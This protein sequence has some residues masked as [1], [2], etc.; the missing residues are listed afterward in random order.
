MLVSS[1]H[2][3]RLSSPSQLASNLEASRDPRKL[4]SYDVVIVAASYKRDHARRS[5]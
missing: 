5:A 4:V 2:R 3:A 1:L